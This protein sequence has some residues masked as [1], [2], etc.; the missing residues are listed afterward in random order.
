MGSNQNQII[1]QALEIVSE[2]NRFALKSITNN[3]EIKKNFYKLSDVELRSE[4]KE[5][6]DKV[7]RSPDPVDLDRYPD[8]DRKFSPESEI[9]KPKPKRKDTNEYKR[10]THTGLYAFLERISLEGQAKAIFQSDFEYAAEKYGLSKSEMRSMKQPEKDNFMRSLGLKTLEEILEMDPEERAKH[11]G[12]EY[13][14]RLRMPS[15]R[16]VNINLGK[17]R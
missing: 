4:L 13:N 5:D 10:P 6:I 11:I 16:I 2:N 3:S 15:S 8:I 9:D 14:D 12:V 17:N 1:K 7:D